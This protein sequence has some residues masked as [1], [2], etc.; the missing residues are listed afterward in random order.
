MFQYVQMAWTLIFGINL[1]I[2]IGVPYLCMMR[3]LQYNDCINKKWVVFITEIIYHFLGCGVP[4]ILTLSMLFGGLLGKAFYGCWIIASSFV[5]IL[6][7][8]PQFT[9]F[10]IIF[11]CYF[12]ILLFIC[13]VKIKTK[14]MILE[15]NKKT[16]I[17]VK[18][19]AQNTA[20]LRLSSYLIVF[21]LCWLPACLGFY[22]S[23]GLGTIYNFS[24]PNNTQLWIFLCMNIWTLV[25]YF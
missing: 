21:L 25:F 6:F 17:I 19:F 14:R 24:F 7:Y 1:F 11:V 13:I 2:R 8:I 12:L 23:N 4:F 5:S 18:I 15:N 10:F 16:N 9:T 3:T 20:T 22:F